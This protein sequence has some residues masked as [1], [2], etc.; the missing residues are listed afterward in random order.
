[1]LTWLGGPWER[2]SPSSI[3]PKPYEILSRRSLLGE[4]NE[5]KRRRI[6]IVLDAAMKATLEAEAAA[7]QAARAADEARQQAA[8]AERL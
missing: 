6:G 4:C 3:G 5:S 8:T 1:M 2:L 7:K